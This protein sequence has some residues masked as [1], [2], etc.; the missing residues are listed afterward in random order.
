MWV[1]SLLRREIAALGASEETFMKTSANLR[2]KPVVHTPS[3]CILVELGVST[4]YPRLY[5]L[6]MSPRQF[7]QGPSGFARALR[8]SLNQV[9]SPALAR[10]ISTVL[11][12]LVSLSIRVY[13]TPCICETNLKPWMCVA[14][15][16]HFKALMNFHPECSPTL[17]LLLVCNAIAPLPCEAFI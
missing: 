15:V 8:N 9:L 7:C 11:T 14:G 5:S 2:D 13:E 17:L 4:M 12:G 10:T 16:N 6:S 1:Q 3:T